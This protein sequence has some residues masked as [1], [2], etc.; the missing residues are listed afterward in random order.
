MS[1]MR[2]A[3]RRLHLWLGLG[4]GG[5]FVLL[6]LTGSALVFYEAIDGWMHPE[7]RVAGAG[8]APGWASPVWDRALATVRTRWPARDGAWRF[9]VTGEPGPVAARYQ[10]PGA[11]HHGRRVMVWLDPEGGRVLREAEWGAYPMTWLY[12]LH[13]D[14]KLGAPGRAAIGWTGLGLL[15]LL[16]SGLASWWPRGRWR[17]ALHFKRDAVPVRRLRDIHKL[18]GLAALPLLA[19]LV[20]TGVMLA[21]PEP[22]DA[23][24]G[25][26][27]GPVQRTAAPRGSG[28]GGAPIGIAQAL[29][30]A[31]RVVPQARLA[32]VEAPGAGGGVYM[33]RVQQ[34]GDPSR[35]FPHSYVYVDAYDGRVLALHDRQ[36]FGASNLVNNWLH[37][38]HDAS[39][40]GPVLRAAVALAGLVPLLLF[41]TGLMRWRRVRAARRAQPRSTRA[42]ASTS[43]SA[44]S[45]A[46]AACQNRTGSR[47]ASGTGLSRR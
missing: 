12:D 2:S 42:A 7:I 26:T 19:M 45:S 21:L 3:V 20:A 5:L 33:V 4:A 18:A 6:G 37:P 27:L 35:R 41:V 34:P 1:R 23:L 30:A 15:V 40:G 38:L 17:Q 14:L 47:A 11:G 43:A 36:R 10:P 28:G 29:A 32:W 24:L 9:E 8:P 16:L 22:S 46:A 13:M 25:R 31:Q 44:A 39:V